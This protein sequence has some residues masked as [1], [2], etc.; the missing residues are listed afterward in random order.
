MDVPSDYDDTIKVADKNERRQPSAAA[1]IAA[2][3]ISSDNL[4]AQISASI[5]EL[6]RSGSDVSD[7]NLS[8]PL[9]RPSTP[10]EPD[11]ES[12]PNPLRSR[13]D[14]TE[15]R[16]QLGSAT[17]S[18]DAAEGDVS[19]TSSP[20]SSLS[21]TPTPPSELE[22]SPSPQPSSSKHNTRPQI[23]QGSPSPPSLKRLSQPPSIASD[24]D[25][26]A[27][28]SKPASRRLRRTDYK[29]ECTHTDICTCWIHAAHPSV[30]KTYAEEGG[31]PHFSEWALGMMEW[32]E[33]AMRSSIEKERD[34]RE[35]RAWR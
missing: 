10:G 19:E 4:A 2:N 16:A 30:R 35:G 21:K 17:I 29:L 15:P 5:Q 8:S 7:F 3:P 27:Q 20:L 9:L 32:P 31:F 1:S 18:L 12:T 11:M 14:S 24:A 23:K 33:S 34:W 28:A 13:Q 6:V 25:R 22:S 26:K